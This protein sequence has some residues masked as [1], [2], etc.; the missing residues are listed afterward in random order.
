MNTNTIGSVAD[1]DV[2]IVHYHAAALVRDAV[3]ALRQDASGSGLSINVLVVDNGSTADELALL[4]SLEVNCLRTGRD[5]GYAGGVNFAFPTT[6]SDYIVLMNEDVMV[7]PGCLNALHGT[8][9][10]GAAVAG[11][12]FYWDRDKVFL[13]PCTE[14][15]SR[16][17]ELMKVAGKRSLA[18]LQRARQRWRD[19]AQ[20]HWRSV[21]PIYSTALSG[22][23]LAFRRDTWA[24]VGPFDEGYQLYFDENDWLLRV[25]RA[26][27]ESMYVPEAKAIHLHNP[28]LAQD[29][30]RLQWASESFLR[31]G[32]RYYGETFTRRLFRVGS[33]QS[34]IPVWEPPD[35][36]SARPE[37]DIPPATAWPLWIELTPSPLGFP[38]AA[39]RITDPSIK[40]WQ[41]PRM[42]GLPF[43]NGTYYLQ[44][45]DDAG[46]EIR[47]YSLRRDA[48]DPNNGR[49][50]IEG[51]PA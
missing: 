7:L 8:L 23:L 35:A 25:E 41:L 13:L 21:Q 22:A 24:A 6:R 17:N 26:G 31:F 39:A 19:H 18:H 4:Q 44:L 30:D 11:P 12:E 49:A 20:R 28:K 34:V 42:N 15:R 5:A 3:E 29:A 40:R 37:I 27:L 46:R 32:N 9:Q 43:L 33:R 50:Q 14:E 38:A 47:G 51:V 2:I 1:V 48:L 45:L 36:H 16:R 10:N